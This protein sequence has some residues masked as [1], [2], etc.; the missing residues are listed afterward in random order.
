MKSGVTP[1]AACSSGVSCWWVVLAGWMTRLFASPMF[2]RCEKSRSR[3]ITFL[4]ASHPP[5]TP[6]PTRAPNPPARYFRARAWDG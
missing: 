4:L 6:N 1:Q 5:F 3:S 2:A